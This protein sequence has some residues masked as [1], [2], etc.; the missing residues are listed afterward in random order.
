MISLKELLTT[1]FSQLTLI[2]AALGYMLKR[3]F[4]TIS[5]KTE[6]NHNLFQQKRLESVN[7]FFKTYAQTEQMWNSIS[8][9][10]ILEH[11]IPAKEMDS[12]IFPH[13]NELKRN[14]LELQIYFDD[15]EHKSFVDILDNVNSI[16][17][18]LSKVYFDY[19]PEKTYIDKSNEFLDHKFQKLKDNKNIFREI[20]LTLKKMFK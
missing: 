4:D 2:L 9:W 11:K 1:Y 3:V 17:S 13:I 8:T 16:N 7:N 5:K 12:I 20:S 10:D 14:V 15:K 18:K 6:I 19:N